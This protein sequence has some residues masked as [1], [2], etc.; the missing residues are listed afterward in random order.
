MYVLEKRRFR[1]N[2]NIQQ[3]ARP[4]SKSMED[5]EANSRIFTVKKSP[6]D[7]GL[8]RF[9]HHL[10]ISLKSYRIVDL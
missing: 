3:V 9:L 4:A 8:M 7:K 2:S 6:V 10:D 5:L 1:K